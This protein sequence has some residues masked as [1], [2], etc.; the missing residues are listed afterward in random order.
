M[1]TWIAVRGD[2]IRGEYVDARQVPNDLR[3]V[4]IDYSDVVAVLEEEG[5]AKFEASWVHL[6]DELTQMRQSRRLVGPGGPAAG[7]A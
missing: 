4:G 5:A 2:A 3:D 6:A 1:P 7:S